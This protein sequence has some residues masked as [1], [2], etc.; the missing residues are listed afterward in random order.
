MNSRS[1]QQSS[2]S[3]AEKG[4]SAPLTT[5]W[6]GDAGRTVWHLSTRA[7]GL[8]LAGFLL[9]NLAIA[10]F[11]VTMGLAYSVVNPPIS[12]FMVQRKLLDH[13]A[14]RPVRFIPIKQIPVRVQ[15]MFI[16]LENSTFYTDPGIDIAAIEHAYRVNKAAGEIVL[17]GSTITQQL[18]RT[19][20][21]SGNKNYFRKWVEALMSVSL[22]AVMAKQRQLELYLNSIEWG[23]GVFGIGAASL[24]Y[25]GKPLSRLSL[26]QTIRLAVIITSPL[27]YGVSTFARNPG[28]AERYDFLWSIY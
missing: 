22:N 5:G 8:L 18:V 10:L 1:T 17:G 24:Y 2:I 14:I 21:L 11:G 7:I 19:L 12:S 26:D 25:Y 27:R 28:M 16:R 6:K 13:F 23:K 4:Y 15:R 3:E 9:A 20:F